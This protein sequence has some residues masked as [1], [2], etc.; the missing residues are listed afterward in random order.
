MKNK[1]FY[2]V[3]T[4][5]KNAVA[6]V[7]ESGDMYIAKEEYVRLKN[8]EIAD[9]YIGLYRW[10]REMCRGHVD[11]P[12]GDVFPI[13]LSPHEEYRLQPVEDT[14]VLTLNI[15]EDK[16]K[17]ISDYAWGYRVNYMY[18]PEDEK[19]EAA[20]NAELKRYGI[21]GESSLIL[22]DEGNYYPFLKQ[23]IIKSWHRVLDTVPRGPEDE[24][25]I[26]FELMPEWLV[27]TERF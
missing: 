8:G 12:E 15:P 16:I 9:Y 5:Q 14:V 23:K 7:L 2:T 17:I 1:D 27:K 19:D 18:I 24:L 6:D 13:W 25:G 22:T 20:F 21:S 10:L 4:R 26:C 3:Y 11:M